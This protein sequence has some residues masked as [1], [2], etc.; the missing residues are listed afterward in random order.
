VRK[1]VLALSVAAVVSAAAVSVGSGAGSANPSSNST[2]NVVGEIYAKA[3]AILR[4]Q[5]VSASFGGSVGSDFPQAQCLVSSQ[6]VTSGGKMSL[7]LDCTADA[8]PE[9]PAVVS[10]ANTPDGATAGGRPTPG[11]PGVVTVIA[12]PVG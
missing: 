8:Q 4:A 7:M 2:Y 5:G 3:V 11:A 12:T 1:L 6:K 9:L 10:A